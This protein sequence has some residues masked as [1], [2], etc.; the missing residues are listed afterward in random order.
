MAGALLFYSLSLGN[1]LQTGRDLNDTAQ[2]IAIMF[3]IMLAGAAV[4]RLVFTPLIERTRR[5]WGLAG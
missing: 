5:R 4:D 3:V 1:L 2:V